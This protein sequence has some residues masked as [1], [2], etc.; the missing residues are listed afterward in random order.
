M[1]KAVAPMQRHDKFT[2]I[3]YMLVMCAHQTSIHVQNNYL[4]ASMPTAS[5]FFLPLQCLSVSV[6]CVCVFF[7]T[8]FYCHVFSIADISNLRFITG[9]KCVRTTITATNAQILEMKEGNK[10]TKC[11]CTVVAWSW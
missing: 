5:M 1:D 11:L 2:H 6:C 10:Q 4:I 9:L 7:F 3:M 8:S